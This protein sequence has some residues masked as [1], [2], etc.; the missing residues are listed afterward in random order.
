MGIIK[1]A[2]INCG[3]SSLPAL[4]FLSWNVFTAMSQSRAAW[5]WFVVLYWSVGPRS[6]VVAPSVGVT[7]H[8]VI[9]LGD[10][11]SASLWEEDPEHQRHPVEQEKYFIYLNFLLPKPPWKAP[12]NVEDWKFPATNT[13][14]TQKCDELL[15]ALK[16]QSENKLKSQTNILQGL[17]HLQM[18]AKSP[19][20]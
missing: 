17:L 2:S 20:P 11:I 4:Y 6:A 3:L 10:S 16:L 13:V 15:F 5:L 7:R 18:S 8:D 19:V 14:Q 9:L 12:R 1:A